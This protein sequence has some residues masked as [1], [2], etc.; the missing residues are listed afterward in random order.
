M[1]SPP[2][3]LKRWPVS[4]VVM[5]G[6]VGGIPIMIYLRWPSG[7][8]PSSGGELPTLDIELGNACQFTDKVRT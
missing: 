3:M 2:D 1:M 5:T 4:G 8:A 6:Q 7:S